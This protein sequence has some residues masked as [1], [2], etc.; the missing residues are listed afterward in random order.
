MDREVG[1]DAR[2]GVGQRQDDR[3]VIGRLDVRYRHQLRREGAADGGILHALDGVDDIGGLEGGAVMPGDA[4]LQLEGDG[5]TVGG[6]LQLSASSGS[7][8]SVS[9]LMNTSASNTVERMVWRNTSIG[10][11]CGS[12]VLT[13]LEMPTT[14]AA[15]LRPCA[16]GKSE[17]AGNRRGSSRPSQ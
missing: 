6:R 10:D 14:I 3:L 13:S 8:C 1:E 12:S 4:G 5:K 16:A 11:I 7:A 9:G 2:H 17:G 15:L